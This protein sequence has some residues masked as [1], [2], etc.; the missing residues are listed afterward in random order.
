MA[1]VNKVALRAEFEAYQTHFKQLCR[2][3][4]VSAECE[5]LFNGMLLL[6][7]LLLAVFLEKTTPKGTHNSGLPSSQTDPDETARRRPGKKGKGPQTETTDSRS[8]RIVVETRTAPVSECRACGHDLKGIAPGGH[9]RRVKVDIVFE[10][11]ELTVKAE[12]K[13]CPR[14]RTETRG[15]FPEDMPASF[16]YGPGI[17]AFATHLLTAQMLSLKRTAQT[18]KALTGRALAEATLL[19]WLTRLNNALAGWETAA[20]ARL[21]TEPVLHADE[22]SLRIA[23]K[24]HWLHSVSAGN[25]VVKRRHR[26]RGGEALRDLDIVPR[27]GGVLVHDR[28]ASYFAFGNCEHALCGSHLLRNLAFIEEAHGHAW[29]RHMGN[30]LLRTCR[31]VREQENKALNDADYQAVRTRYRTLL[32]QAKRELPTPPKRLA[33]QRGRPAKSD[34]ENLHEALTNYETEALR[35]ARDPDV[36]FTNNRAERDIRMAKV[37]QKVAGCFRTATYADAYCRI[38]SYLQSM[39]CQGYNPLSAIE[40][41]LNGN[42]ATMVEKPLKNKPAKQDQNNP[43]KQGQDKRSG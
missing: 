11:T 8:R 28:W 18:L 25:L 15:A 40:I 2:D 39:A 19:A 32:T 13:T 33:G 21:L 22:T 38:S 9:E 5:T 30:L 14:C 34:A 3:G 20:I 35:F 42:A 23:G 24:Q 37:K 17:V 12:V 43:A 36:P 26:K 29:A 16:Q 41:A 6:F 31:R 7:E 4:K 10:T 1:T 27:Y